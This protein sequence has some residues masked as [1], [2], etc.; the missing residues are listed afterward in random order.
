ME[1][2][3]L[4]ASSPLVH[5]DKVT[6]CHHPYASKPRMGHA[7]SS[8]KKIL[9]D[10]DE[11]MSPNHSEKKD[12]P[13]RDNLLAHEEGTQSNSDFDHPQMAL[14]QSMLNKFEMRQ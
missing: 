4:Y 2:D 13:R 10:E 5:K 9:D 6:G 11:N 8:R 7:S 12:E 3:E 14:T 1:G